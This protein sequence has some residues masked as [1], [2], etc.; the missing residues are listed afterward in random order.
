MGLLLL[1]HAH[2]RELLL[3]LTVIIG[4]REQPE[5]F[6]PLR[7]QR[8]G[9]Q[10]VIRIH[11]HVAHPSL[12]GFVLRPLHVLAAQSV[13]LEHPCLD[14]TLDVEHDLERKRRNALHE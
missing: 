10:S 13:R 9:D 14:F 8:I 4:L 5:F 11:Q 2:G 7:F 12:V 6:V 1:R 3:L